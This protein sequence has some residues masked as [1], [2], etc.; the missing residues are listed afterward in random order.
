MGV[1]LALPISNK[2]MLS[3]NTLSLEESEQ[4]ALTEKERGLSPSRF[5][6]AIDVI[7]NDSTNHLDILYFLPANNMSDLI[8]R[9]KMRS[10]STHYA[11]DNFPQMD[12]FKTTKS[13]NVYCA[14]DSSLSNDPIFNNSILS[15][16]PQAHAVNTIFSGDVTVKKLQLFL[17]SKH[18]NNF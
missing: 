15:K 18:G 13:L 5:S 17:S 2:I 16:F 14:Y 1:I 3:F 8:L 11:G 4:I 12:E 6:S 7:E 9:T 10:L